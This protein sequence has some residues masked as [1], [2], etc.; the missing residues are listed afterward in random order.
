VFADEEVVDGLKVVA[1]KKR[2]KGEA[3][4][5]VVWMLQGRDQRGSLSLLY[6]RK[7]RTPLVSVAGA[8]GPRH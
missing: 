4:P 3:S 8:H 6:C 7:R 1:G 5:Y 2:E